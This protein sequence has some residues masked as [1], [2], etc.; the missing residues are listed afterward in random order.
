MT[1]YSVLPRVRRAEYAVQTTYRWIHYSVQRELYRVL[2]YVMPL[3][4]IIITL[5]R[6]TEQ[7]S[8]FAV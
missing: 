5:L 2:H 7:Q 6:W 8:L 4:T 3:K 1:P